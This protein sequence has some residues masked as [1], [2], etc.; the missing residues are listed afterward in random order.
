MTAEIAARSRPSRCEAGNPDRARATVTGGPAGFPSGVT[1]HAARCPWF[2]S[3]ASTG[4]ARSSFRHGTGAGAAFHDASTYHRPRTG[5]QLMS[6][7]TAP[8][9]AWAATSPPR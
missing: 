8:V 7:R 5:S 3:T 2:R 4:C 6:Y 9:A 1:A